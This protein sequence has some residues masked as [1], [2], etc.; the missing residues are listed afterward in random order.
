MSPADQVRTLILPLFE[1]S[2][3]GLYDVEHTGAVLRVSIERPG[4]V[5]L[6]VIAGL[7]REISHL[8]DEHD[9]LPGRYTLEVS[10][11]GL[12]RPLRT[13]D[14]F[15]GAV[16]LTVSVKTVAGAGD[17][18]RIAGVLTAFDGDV[19]TISSDD[20]GAA[21]TSDGA[22]VHT[23]RLAD[24]ER[25]RTTFAWGPGPKPGSPKHRKK[26]ATS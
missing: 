23:V 7:T 25:A 10:S 19:L 14:H 2:G 4:G 16:G 12:E 22:T 15:R 20:D 13:L 5:D 17:E 8:L 21:D 3:V 6:D 9:P 11:P 26:A 1:G 24:V 18:R